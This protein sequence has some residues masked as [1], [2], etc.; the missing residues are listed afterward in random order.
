MRDSITAIFPQKCEA[1]LYYHV[2]LRIGAL[3]HCIAVIPRCEHPLRFNSLSLAYMYRCLLI[4][5]FRMPCNGAATNESVGT[6][7]R[8]RC[9]RRWLC[10]LRC[11]RARR[12]MKVNLEMAK[13][14][15]I[16]KL[17]L[18]IRSMS[19]S[20]RLQHLH[21]TLTFSMSN[22]CTRR[23]SGQVGVS[24]LEAAPER[25]HVGTRRSANLRV[26]RLVAAR[27]TSELTRSTTL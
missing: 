7:I 12:C 27:P 2:A 22:S 16:W 10:S 13:T 20:S 6:I 9:E 25:A 18:E 3:C 14:F 4:N 11:T 8:S 15:H 5:S 26:W 21:D 1:S 17:Q 19:V 23:P 24:Q